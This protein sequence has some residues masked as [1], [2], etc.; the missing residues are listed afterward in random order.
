MALSRDDW[1]RAALLAIAEG[2]TG[3]VAVE[4]LA[5]RLGATK[6]SF[7]WHFRSRGELLA[8]ALATW[9]R[10]ATDAI[11]ERLGDVADPVERLRRTLVA[12]MEDEDDEYGAIDAALLASAADPSVAP[13]VERVHAKRLAFLERCFLDMGLS[14]TDARVR[15]R[16]GYSIYLGWFRQHQ[17]RG[18]APPSKRELRAYQRAAIELLAGARGDVTREGAAPPQAAPPAPRLSSRPASR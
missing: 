5:A 8:A 14:R 15:A 6:G 7:Y 13:V 17:A 9:E 16:L 3:A 4:P 12:A 10:E 18:G 2:G 1:T 11:I